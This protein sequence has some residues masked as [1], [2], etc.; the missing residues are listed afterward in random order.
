LIL[1][2]PSLWHDYSFRNAT[3]LRRKT[4]KC[5]SLGLTVLF[6]AIAGSALAQNH[7]SGTCKYGKADP[8]STQQSIE[9]GDQPGHVL[10]IGKSSCTW[11]VPVEMAGLKSK[12]ANTAETV[13]V[14][15]AKFADRGYSVIA[16][17]NGDKVYGR[18]QG[19]GGMK[20]GGPGPAEGT[21]SFTGGTGKLKGVKG[22]GTWKT[23]GAPNGEGELQVEG[24]Y[25][26]PGPSGT[27]K[28]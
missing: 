28:K 25:S 15:V 6:A 18:Y 8:S 17:E 26:L 14:T 11:S 21:W 4:M 27:A 3:I 16:M 19:T 5:K 13:D 2:R 20:D 9:V 24:E 22:K 10:V 7:I 12:T 1:I 23:S